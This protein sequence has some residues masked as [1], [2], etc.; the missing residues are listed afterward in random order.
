MIRVR[1][2]DR[3]THDDPPAPESA[4]VSESHTAPGGNPPRES[5]PEAPGITSAF[6]RPCPAARKGSKHRSGLPACDYRTDA[7]NGTAGDARISAC[8]GKAAVRIAPA[9]SIT[10]SRWRGI[11]TSH[12]DSGRHDGRPHAPPQRTKILSP[13]PMLGS[14]VLLNIRMA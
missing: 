10:A 8:N 7:H 9:M 5:Q 13:C 11:R 1:D 2:D 4:Q 6:S 14:A 3:L 12:Q